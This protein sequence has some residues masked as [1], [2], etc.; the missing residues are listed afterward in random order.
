MRRR[1]LRAC[2]RS[3]LVPSAAWCLAFATA[4]IAGT[5]RT[6]SAASGDCIVL[7]E[8]FLR[9]AAKASGQPP[10]PSPDMKRPISEE[11]LKAL[12]EALEPVPLKGGEG[13]AIRAAAEGKSPLP[14]DR[15]GVVVGDAVT[16]LA[17]LHARETLE[18][19]GK[20]RLTPE[21]RRT[22]TQD[23]RRV[24]GCGEARFA[25]RGGA[26]AVKTSLEL[27][28]Q[29]RGQL[30]QLLLEKLQPRRAGKEGPR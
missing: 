11:E 29:H 5:P 26:G 30:E 28:R 6:T 23:F 17:M 14:P 25:S 24:I 13:I 2:S 8:P 20:G 12:I 10:Q 7:M 16:L 21:Q 3:P 22:L 19:L 9:D 15:F 1:R 4:L 27:V 18:V